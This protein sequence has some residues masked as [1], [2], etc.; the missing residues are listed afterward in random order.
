MDKIKNDIVSAWNSVCLDLEKKLPSHAIHAWFDPIT[1]V[2]F[3]KKSFVLEV[4]NQF[5]LEWIESHYKDDI[6]LSIETLFDKQI[7]YRLLVAKEKNISSNEGSLNE[8]RI[9][10]R[11]KRFNNL[12]S[13]SFNI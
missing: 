7:K 6:I 9:R 3:Q 2:D 10:T 11:I 4:P 12:N 5:S 1:V 8:P 13:I